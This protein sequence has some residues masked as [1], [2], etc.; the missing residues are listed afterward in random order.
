MCCGS[1]CARG[2]AKALDKRDADGG[3]PARAFLRRARQ[4]YVNLL[5]GGRS[6][7][8]GDTPDMISARDGFLAAGHFAP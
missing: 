7:P 3:V 8:G 4:G 5:P 1:S 6:V 2:A